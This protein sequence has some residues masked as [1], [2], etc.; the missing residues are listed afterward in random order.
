MKQLIESLLL[1]HKNNIESENF[2]ENFDSS[3]FF[4]GD[5]DELTKLTVKIGNCS[6]EINQSDIIF[7]DGLSRQINLT[8][9]ID[10]FIMLREIHPYYPDEDL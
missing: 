4:E 3:V 9:I 6:V 10:T 1:A 7:R 5:E 2:K 8:E